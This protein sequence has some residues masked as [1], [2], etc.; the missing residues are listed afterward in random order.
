MNA[1]VGICLAA[2]AI[3][4]DILPKV[5]GSKDYYEK[6]QKSTEPIVQQANSL[7]IEYVDVL[8]RINNNFLLTF[9]SAACQSRHRDSLNKASNTSL[10]YSRSPRV[11]TGDLNELYLNLVNNDVETSEFFIFFSSQLHPDAVMQPAQIIDSSTK[12]DTSTR[13]DNK[14]SKSLV[15][16][17]RD[18]VGDEGNSMTIHEEYRIVPVS[19]VMK[20]KQQKQQLINNDEENEM[21]S[22]TDTVESTKGI[23][24]ISLYD[25]DHDV[26][27]FKNYEQKKN[28]SS[29]LSHIRSSSSGS[30]SARGDLAH[31]RANNRYLDMMTAISDRDVYSL[32]LSGRGGMS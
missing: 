9:T 7:S 2:G 26:S 18:G 22:I 1:E 20:L 23:D 25:D 31:Q 17:S 10:H 29:F 32:E 13:S 27:F 5:I 24:F 15:P 12:I 8:H 4:T 30:S 11:A 3:A 14:A 16:S 6:V 19:E 28:E 21:K